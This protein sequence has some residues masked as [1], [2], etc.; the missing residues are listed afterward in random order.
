[1]SSILTSQQKRSEAINQRETVAQR[2]K[3]AE[4]Y[5]F[6]SRRVM[7]GRITGI[8]MAFVC[9]VLTELLSHGGTKIRC[10]LVLK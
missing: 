2:P 1:M 4:F 10:L 9:F 8:H 3:R 5:S 6:T 7:G